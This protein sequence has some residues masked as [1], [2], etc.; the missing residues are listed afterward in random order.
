[1]RIRGPALFALAVAVAA[2]AGAITTDGSK[3]LVCA[4]SRGFDCSGEGCDEA[5][6]Q[7]MN[8][9][10][11]LRVDL[12]AKTLSALDPELADESMTIASVESPQG[13]LVLHGSEGDRGW[14]LAIDVASGDSVL[15]VNDPKIGI[16]VFGECGDDR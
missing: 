7:A 15:T 14:S 13:R 10:D 1:M 16:V 4:Q 2:P 6:P 5:T 3:P 8:V 11:I 12:K 9:P